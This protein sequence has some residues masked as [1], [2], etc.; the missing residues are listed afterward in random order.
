ML[1]DP[2]FE[3]D[4]RVGTEQIG[5]GDLAD[6]VAAWKAEERRAWNERRSRTELQSLR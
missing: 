3:V 6:L 1:H 4:P 2:L 5:F